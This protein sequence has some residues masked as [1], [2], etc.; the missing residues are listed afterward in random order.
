MAAVRAF[1]A[2]VPPA[3]SLAPLVAA[4][5]PLR[6]PGASWVPPERLHVT[7]A[8][9]G[10]VSDR[11]A[12]RL[13]VRLSSAARSA[14][15]FEL[16]VEGGGAFPRPARPRVLWAGLAGDVPALAALAVAVGAEVPYVPHVTVARIREPHY[17]ATDA[18]AA[19]EGVR[20]EPWTVTEAVLMR[21]VPGPKPSYDVVARA[22][23][24]YQA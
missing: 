8:F 22:P 16:R 19:L 4:V 11:A 13:A 21:S 10:E 20:G 12:A 17:D 3:T 18:L 24:G 9:H 1:F 23:L 5:S 7:L 15:P 14:V 2:V 6:G